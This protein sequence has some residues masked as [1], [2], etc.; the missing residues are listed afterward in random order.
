MA[1]HNSGGALVAVKGLSPVFRPVPAPTTTIAELTFDLPIG[2]GANVIYAIERIQMVQEADLTF[3]VPG[4]ADADIDEQARQELALSVRQGLTAMPEFREN[5]TFWK[6]VEEIQVQKSAA[7]SLDTFRK[8]LGHPLIYVPF[9]FG[10][11]LTTP[12]VSLYTILTGDN[13]PVAAEGRMELLI[14][15]IMATSDDILSIT[16]GG[17]GFV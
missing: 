11:H 17:E 6:N 10:V 14:R 3:T 8:T 4:A 7:G 5:G 13:T 9:P 16:R 2:F 15:P 1:R 12:R